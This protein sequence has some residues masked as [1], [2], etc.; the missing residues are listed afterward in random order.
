MPRE[1][2]GRYT[3]VV[4]AQ[5]PERERV[6][7]LAYVNGVVTAPEDAVVRIDDRGFQFGD[8]VYEVIRSY[9][10]RLWAAERHFARLQRSLR[11]LWLDGIDVTEIAAAARGLYVQSGIADALLYIQITRG[12][13]PRDYALAKNA[14]PTVV[15]TVRP[16]RPLD[17]GRRL[18]GVRV[19]LRPDLRWARVD[20]KSLNL[21]A[22]MMAKKEAAEA[23]AFEAVLQRDGM[24]TEGASTSLFAVRDGVIVTREEGTHILPGVTRE[25]VIE[26]AGEA[27]IPVDERPYTVDELLGAD[28]AFL[29]GTSFGVYGIAAIDGSLRPAPGTVTHA[30]N[31]MYH[32]WVSEG[33]DAPA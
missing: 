2:D 4:P 3:H 17:P 25:L 9:R 27:G 22:N 8:G 1:F 31:T 15:M 11:G 16:I 10:G 6:R 13:T 26:C 19:A 7:Q 14:A 29:T 30:L 20:I 5:T 21:L 24:V 18:R 23:Q 32:Q 12:A 33:R 28:E